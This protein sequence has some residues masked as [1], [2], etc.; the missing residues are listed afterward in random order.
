VDA[1]VMEER[2]SKMNEEWLKENYPSPPMEDS[3]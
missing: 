3:E 1:N 2:M